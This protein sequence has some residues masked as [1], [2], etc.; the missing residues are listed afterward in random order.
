MKTNLVGFANRVLGLFDAEIVRKADCDRL[1]TG[2]IFYQPSYVPSALPEEASRYLTPE[3][4]RL[5]ELRDRYAA[6][7]SPVTDRSVWS[8]RY[9]NRELDLRFFRGDNAYIWQYRDFNTEI[10]YLLTAYYA[11]TIDTLRAMDRLGEDALFGVYT[12][13]FNGRRI[14]RDLLD[15]VV[16]MNFL[17][18]HLGIASRPSLRVVDIGAG[19][20]RLAH[21]MVAALPNIEYAYCVDAIPESTFLSEFYLRFRG[22]GDRTSVVPLDQVEETLSSQQITIAT[23]VHSF[24]ECTVGSIRWWL[25]LLQKLGISHLMIVTGDR[26]L[27]TEPDGGRI[28]FLPYLEESGYA[29]RVRE[30]KYSAP[31]VQ[32]YGV[33]PAFH[34]LFELG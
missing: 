33:T 15:S 9:V 1:Q 6:Y 20:G 13:D 12:F 18:R 11:E 4:P 26:L 17:E 7:A 34:Y 10:K 5:R 21:R 32:R 22:V 31:S 23:N 29:L 3:N 14:S 8:Q 25:A 27:S 2:E 30:P 24:Q 28:D 19:Y 16:E